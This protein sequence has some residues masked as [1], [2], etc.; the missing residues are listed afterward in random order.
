[1]TVA[2]EPEGCGAGGADDAVGFEAQ[3]WRGE[4]GGAG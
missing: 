1:V 4:L 2:L 3:F